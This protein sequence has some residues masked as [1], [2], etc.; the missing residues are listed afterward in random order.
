MSRSADSYV[1]GGGMVVIV[2]A[3]IAALL[4]RHAGL[5]RFRLNNRG[6]DPELD[7]VLVAFRMAELTWR[8]S[9]TGTA[10]AAEPELDANYQWLSTTQVATITGITDRGVRAAIKRGDLKAECTDGRYR[11]SREQLA[12]WRAIRRNR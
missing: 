3:R 10:R 6:A 11:I 4:N 1:H 5:E 2:P 12:H 7:A 9:V 8:N